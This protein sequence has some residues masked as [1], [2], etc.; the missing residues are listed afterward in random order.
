VLGRRAVLAGVTGDLDLE[1][2]G[3]YLPTSG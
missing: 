1:R 2:R 3:D